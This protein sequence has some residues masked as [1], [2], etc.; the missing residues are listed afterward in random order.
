M[1]QPIA[2]R[3][4]SGERTSRRVTPAAGDSAD[5]DE[6]LGGIQRRGPGWRRARKGTL[7][8]P[9]AATLHPGDAPPEPFS[10]RADDRLG[11]GAV[12]LGAGTAG[13]GPGAAAPAASRADTIRLPFSSIGGSDGGSGIATGG[14]W[15]EG[16]RRCLPRTLDGGAESRC[17]GTGGEHGDPS[18]VCTRRQVGQRSVPWSRERSDCRGIP[19]T[20]GSS[21]SA[22]AGRRWVSHAGVDESAHVDSLSP[23]VRGGRGSA[24]RGRCRG[25]T[26]A[27]VTSSEVPGTVAHLYGIFIPE[28]DMCR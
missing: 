28:Y 7:G 6:V 12:S 14:L 15:D 22:R 26:D 20:R 5:L 3:S 10:D 19:A 11:G 24:H 25:T 23:A 18:R 8:K 2:R 17:S 21:L 1:T 9:V 27:E 16:R 4:A 13:G